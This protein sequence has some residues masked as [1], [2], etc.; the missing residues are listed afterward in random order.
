MLQQLNLTTEDP[1]EEN[2]DEP[3]KTKWTFKNFG[4]KILDFIQASVTPMLPGL[5][6]GGMCKV[7]LLLIVTFINPN[8]AKT[9]SYMLLSAI[10]DAPFYFMP[11]MV[12]Y[13][14]ATKLGGTPAYS[15]MATGA[16]LYPTFHDIANQLINC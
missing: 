16:L 10:A 5:I 12:A 14:A 6:A 9:S 13:G 4:G 2:L 7:A 15:M 8:F 3:S 11:I 1:V